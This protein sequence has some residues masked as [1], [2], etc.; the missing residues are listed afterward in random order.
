MT[1][2]GEKPKPWWERICVS[3]LGC[4]DWVG[5]RTGEGYG[6]AWSGGKWRPAHRLVYE[7]EIGEIPQGLVIDHLCRNHGCVNPAHL[8]P[9]T[10]WE[11]VHGRGI[12]RNSLV[13]H[14]PRGHAYAGENLELR[15]G[16]RH[17]KECRRERVRIY[18][19]KRRRMATEERQ[20]HG[21][22]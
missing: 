15:K 17:C 14:C 10:N 8:E 5:K 20:Q 1:P 2:L 13:T 21:T 18:Q 3:P 7:E 19:R 11:N 16:R 4:W 12:H 6:Q 22:D 9:V